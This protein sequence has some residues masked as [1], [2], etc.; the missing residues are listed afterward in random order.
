MK[1]YLAGPM[2]GYPEFNFPAFRRAAA[3]LRH[4]DHEVFSPAE[5]DDE[6][7]GKDVSQGNLAGDEEQAAKEVGLTGLAL[8]RNVFGRDTTYIC[9]QAEAIAMLPG[10]E[11]SLG[12]QAEWAL[13]RAL[14]LDIIYLR[15]ESPL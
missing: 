14:G 1:I 8:K 5:A 6:E 10:W 15:P 7:F 11:H 13:A 9:Q 4:Y 3:M 2:R 12:A